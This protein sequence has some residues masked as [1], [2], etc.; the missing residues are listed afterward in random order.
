MDMELGEIES[1]KCKQ[2]KLY[3]L[4]QRKNK[5]SLKFILDNQAVFTPNTCLPPQIL[6]GG[7]KH[8]ASELQLLR[9]PLTNKSYH[10]DEVFHFGPQ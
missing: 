10:L 5:N 9:G 7:L 8:M 4:L 3:N 2:N 6:A 1:A